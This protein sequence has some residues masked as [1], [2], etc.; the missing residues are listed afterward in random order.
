[1]T[2]LLRLKYFNSISDAIKDLGVPEEIS[3]V[4]VG[5]QKYLYQEAA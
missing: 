3:K 2:P 1:L 4:F 5:F